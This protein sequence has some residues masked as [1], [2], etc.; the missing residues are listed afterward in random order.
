MLNRFIVTLCI[1]FGLGLYTMAQDPGGPCGNDCADLLPQAP[2]IGDWDMESPTVVGGAGTIVT[3]Q[4]GSSFTVGSGQAPDHPV[5]CENYCGGVFGGCD[6]DIILPDINGNAA[7]VVDSGTSLGNVLDF[8]ANAGGTEAHAVIHGRSHRDLDDGPF[9]F[10][11]DD[12]TL[13]FCVLAPDWSA[14]QDRAII[15]KWGTGNPWRLHG[16]SGG[17]RLNTNGIGGLEGPPMTNNKWQHVALVVDQD[18]AG[19]S[20]GTSE[21]FI[22]CVSAG[23]SSWDTSPPLKSTS[24]LQI[25]GFQQGNNYNP[26]DGAPV[27]LDNIKWYRSALDAADLADECT[28][29][30]CANLDTDAIIEAVCAAAA[31]SFPT[32]LQG[33]TA[34]IAAQIADDELKPCAELILKQMQ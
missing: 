22:D 34:A 9:Q 23:T 15:G 14:T 29:C 25:V 20:G 19:G 31:G 10:G 16:E 4:T 3:E 30:G 13:S 12:A 28:A 17:V 2:L 18:Q 11:C 33:V 32:S 7:A 27:K 8:T 5:Q 24:Q 21:L 1:T 26:N 6:I